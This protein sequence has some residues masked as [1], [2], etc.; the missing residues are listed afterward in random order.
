MNDDVQSESIPDLVSQF[1]EAY[2]DAAGVECSEL[3]GAPGFGLQG[4]VGMDLAATLLVVGVRGI[5]V[6]DVKA[7][8]CLVANGA[9]QH[10]VRHTG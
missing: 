10:R 2:A 7:N 8:H 4:T 6:L 1:H 9:G 3:A 5:N